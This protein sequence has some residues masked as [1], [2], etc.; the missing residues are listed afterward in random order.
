M[1]NSYQLIEYSSFSSD[2]QMSS[3]RK[4]IPFTIAC[5]L[6]KYLSS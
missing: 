5:V 6:A 3:S 1:L 2:W 4:G